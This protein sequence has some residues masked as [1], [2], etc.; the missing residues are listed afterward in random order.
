MRQILFV[1]PLHDWIGANVSWLN[2]LPNVPVYGYGL[3]LFCA[4]LGCVSLAKR[5]CKKE[6][7]DGNLMLDMAIWLFVAGIA[8]AR[9]VYVIQYWNEH[10]FAERP[11][12]H[13]IALW[14]GGLV[15]YGSI[16]GGALGYFAYHWFYLRP[17]GIPHWK[18]ADVIA[19]CIPLG[20]A[21]GRIGCLFTGCC[22]GNVAC[23]ECPAIH[24]PIQSAGAKKMLERGLQ[25]P[26]G[27]LVQSDGR[28]VE[29]VEPGSAA[30]FA[31]L[32]PND[33]IRDINGKDTLEQ[34]W[35]PTFPLNL[36]VIRNGADV[37]LPPFTPTSIGL[38]PTQIYETISM[39]LLLFF[40]LSYYPFKRHDGELLVFLM[41]GYGIHRFLNEMLRTDTDPV[42]FDLTL[43]Q[44][45]SLLVLAI[46]VVVAFFVYRRPALTQAP[47]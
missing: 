44:N 7:I 9:T 36:N 14:D 5:M 33:V 19:P 12:W 26:L 1:V 3:M 37:T 23:S 25:T 15:F 22:F 11:F 43:S 40:L 21:L 6:G 4:F 45:V 13:I 16:F 32:Q 47:S 24:F 28:S 20:L 31:G 46:G 17:L 8:G 38:H 39:L 2:F 30:A 42:A 27:F 41:F 10:K 18:M 34:L 35:N 29:G